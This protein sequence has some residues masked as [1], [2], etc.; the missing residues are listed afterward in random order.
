MGGLDSNL[1]HLGPH[2]DFHLPFPAPHRRVE[3]DGPKH[4]RNYYLR[5]A[6][7]CDLGLPLPGSV[8][9]TQELLGCWCGWRLPVRPPSGVSR[10]RA[11]R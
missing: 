4:V 11:G 3:E 1:Y 2:E 6:F 9:A 7:Y 10:A 5:N 8:S